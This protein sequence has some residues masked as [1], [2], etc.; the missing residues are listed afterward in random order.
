MQTHQD[1]N[2]NKYSPHQITGTN[3]K[4]RFEV[5]YKK[6][7]K[8][9]GGYV[10]DPK[11]MGGETYAGISRKYHP[12]WSGWHIVDKYTLK[13]NQKIDSRELEEMIMQFYYN[14]FWLP[15]AGDYIEKQEV[16]NAVYDWHVN[17]GKS[18]IKAIQRLLKVKDDGIVGEKTIEALNSTTA[19]EINN[20][21][22]YFLKDIVRRK[23]EQKRFLKGW[24]NRVKDFY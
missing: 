6:T 7:A 18:A 3:H 5:A 14:N 20:E 11:D 17:S 4:S 1:N 8:W 2:G 19:Q 12:N 10:D 23:P 16:A 22:E 24:L 9:E 21:R 15:I 13:Y